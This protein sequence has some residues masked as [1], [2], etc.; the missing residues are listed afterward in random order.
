MYVV[1]AEGTA[2]VAVE[3]ILETQE[4]AFLSAT[5]MLDA[6]NKQQET[7]KHK[8]IKDGFG[9]PQPQ[10]GLPLPQGETGH[11][12]T[13]THTHTGLFDSQGLAAASLLLGI[14]L[15]DLR[16]LEEDR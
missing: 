4:L 14:A 1:V 9:P 8:H 5:D 10:N 7:K 15:R 11:T 6:S 2:L 13:H 3:T 16:K 12:H